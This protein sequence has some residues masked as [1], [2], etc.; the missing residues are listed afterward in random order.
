MDENIFKTCYIALILLSAL[1]DLVSVTKMVATTIT[2]LLLCD[3]AMI[4]YM[5]QC[6]NQ[7]VRQ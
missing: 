5:A 7:A 3:L 1:N 6:I 4:I 2:F